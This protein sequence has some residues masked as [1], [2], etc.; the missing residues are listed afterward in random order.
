M[1][2]ICIDC[3]KLRDA[4]KVEKCKECGTWYKIESGCPTCHPSNKTE[5]IPNTKGT[6]KEEPEREEAKKE[7]SEKEEEAVCCTC[8]ETS[9]GKS[10]CKD[11]YYESLDFMNE[12]DKNKTIADMQD[13]YF[14]LYDSIWR[15][16]NPNFIRSN[17][18][19][20]IAIA[21]F[22]EKSNRSNYLTNRAYND[23]T[24]IIHAKIH[25]N[26]QTLNPRIS[27]KAI[28]SDQKQERWIKAQDGHYVLSD[29]ERQIDDLLYLNRIVHSYGQQIYGFPKGIN[30]KCD[31]F[32][33]INGAQ[34]IYIE[35]YGMDTAEYTRD[36]DEKEKYYKECNVPHIAIEKDEMNGDS[37]GFTFRLLREIKDLA[38]EY[39]RIEITSF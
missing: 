7:E 2:P 23:V 38:K 31:W 12:L 16:K 28:E 32:I 10:Q 4:G 24:K 14:N 3:F 25:P 21:L 34:G 18:N 39:Y 33:P 8:G 27:E 22:N 17:C 35:Y 13:H 6:Q 20:L 5:I 15:M 19:R 1:Y 26:P 37:Q 29:K 11:C 30:K 36:R 9:N